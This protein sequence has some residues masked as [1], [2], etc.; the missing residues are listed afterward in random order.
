MTDRVH[1]SIYSS[2]A[3]ALAIFYSTCV[4]HLQVL[5]HSDNSSPLQA[6]TG[7]IIRV[8]QLL[9]T[10]CGCEEVCIFC[11]LFEPIIRAVSDM[12]MVCTAKLSR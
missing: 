9:V 8:H 6:C 3:K 10:A 2:V 7:L 1:S 12:A 11:S 5:T 4:W